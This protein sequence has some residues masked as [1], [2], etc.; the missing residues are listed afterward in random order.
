MAN[1]KVTGLAALTTPAAADLLHLIDDV[2]GT[3]TN[4][5]VLLSAL[6]KDISVTPSET[7]AGL[8]PTDRRHELGHRSAPP[9]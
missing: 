5:K 2:A 7:A 3:P 6:L 4:K 9:P 1:K 8:P